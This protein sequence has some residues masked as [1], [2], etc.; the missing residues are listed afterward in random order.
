MS[1]SSVDFKCC[2]P[3]SLAGFED[4]MQD[5]AAQAHEADAGERAHEPE[6]EALETAQGADQGP[7]RPLQRSRSRKPNKPNKRYWGA[8][9]DRSR[10][11][12]SGTQTPVSLAQRTRAQQA[13]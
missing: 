9:E 1:G 6:E 3:T 5:E 13:Y 7:I 11:K 2:S 10:R 12:H 8:F 4:P